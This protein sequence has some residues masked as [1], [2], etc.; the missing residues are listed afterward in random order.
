[1]YRVLVDPKREKEKRIFT[2]YGTGVEITEECKRQFLG[3]VQIGKYVF[4][5]FEEIKNDKE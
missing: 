4:H 5:L 2:M 3:T 1:M